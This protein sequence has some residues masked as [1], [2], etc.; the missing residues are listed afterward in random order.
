MKYSIGI[1]FGTSSGRVLIIDIKTGS[2]KGMSVLQY[3]NGTIEK[4]LNNTPLPPNFALQDSKDYMDVIEKGIPEA[5]KSAGIRP[6]DI[7]GLG[8]DFTSST[9]IVTDED[10]IPLSWRE[11][12]K[13]NPHAY[14]KLWKHHGAIEEANAM[15]NLAKTVNE[16]WISHY[17]YEVTSEWLIP[18]VLELK[19]N[20]PDLLNKAAYIIE[21]GDWIV[22]RLV[23]ENVRSNCARGFKSFWNE[24]DG[25]SH[26]FFKEIDGDLPTIIDEKLEGKLVKI[27]ETAGYLT[28]KWSKML[29]L[30]IGLPI[31]TA[32][33]D[34]HSALLGVGSIQ[35]NQFTMV[36]GTSTCHLMLNEVQK[37][38]RGISGS[39]KDAIIP[40]LFAYEAGQSAVGDLFE[41]IVEQAPVKYF[42]EAEANDLSIF[43]LLE[44]KAAKTL[45]GS[46][47]LVALDWHNGNRSPLSNNEL[48]GV[49]IGQT[50]HTKFE[51]IY[52]AH[53]EAT[54]YGTMMILE[55]YE[56][57]GMTVDEVFACGGLP[58]K[59][60]LLMQIYADI[61]NRPIHISA[62]DYASGIGAAILGSVAGGGHNTIEEA[63]EDMKQ[64]LLDVV[65]PIPKNVATYKKLFEVYKT[66]H[67]YFGIEKS[68]K[69]KELKKIAT[70]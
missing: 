44:Q 22:S 66:L 38:I 48:S 23:N 41:Y 51:D 1:D 15:S 37:K 69:M 14:V 50:L 47:G 49:L 56:Q 62:S 13:E 67:N 21:A 3:P 59:N 57:F 2:I 42:E 25:F 36:M 28:E 32:I 26:D 52:R 16:N 34:A 10:L 27:G 58:Q 8:V 53:L 55:A 30:P 11:E 17:G 45:A 18:K 6:N 46:S 40:D 61:L 12:H 70:R 4:T 68:E 24:A 9:M 60:A 29:G 63:V 35:K 5:I 64:P 39:V 33:I 54:A 31:A 7:I 43:D 65:K 19:N 20:A